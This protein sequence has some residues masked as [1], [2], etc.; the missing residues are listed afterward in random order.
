MAPKAV[1][2]LLPKPPV[3]NCGLIVLWALA[4]LLGA[5]SSGEGPGQGSA[6]AAPG[7]PGVSGGATEASQ[8]AASTATPVADVLHP[9]LLRF[10]DDDAPH[11]ALTEWWY[12]NGHLWGTGG[13][14]Y[15]FMLTVFKRQPEPAR[16][17]YVAHVAVTD[18]QRRVFQFKEELTISTELME[19]SQGFR[20]QVGNTNIRGSGGADR[21]EGATNDYALEL[22]LQAAKPPVLHGKEGFISV[23]DKEWSYYYSRTR[24]Q[25]QGFLAHLGTAVPVTGLA[26]MDHQWG[27]FTLEGEGGWDWFGLLLE[28]GT[29]MM[30]SV[31]R[32][33]NGRPVY[34]YG[35]VVDSDG[36]KTHLDA[37]QFQ[38]GAMG[39][40]TSPDTGGVYPMGWRVKV[41]LYGLEAALQPVL[42]AQEMT[43]FSSVGRA[44]WEG[45]VAIIGVQNGAPLRGQGYVEL[46]GYA[47]SSPPGGR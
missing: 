7:A 38:V 17:G 20:L 34:A 16:A 43:T 19:S 47:P 12:Y 42:E 15:G 10:P 39:S 29:D 31:I 25:V 14:Q 41:P 37:T 45:Q 36:Q 35:T 32:G 33:G 6:S 13:E 44:Y 8:S 27:N 1:L 24:M 5:C 28:D 21:L 30:I 4:L 11:K 23:S 26:W 3:V 40:W 22:T 2:C 9:Q 18:H 46:T